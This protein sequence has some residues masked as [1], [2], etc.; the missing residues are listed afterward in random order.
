MSKKNNDLDF[1]D[2]PVV[3]TLCFQGRGHGFYPCQG[4]ESPHASKL[5]QKNILFFLTRVGKTDWFP[6]QKSSWDTA[7]SYWGWGWRKQ[8]PV[9]A[10]LSLGRRKKQP[11]NDMEREHSK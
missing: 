10:S 6:N 5:S 2:G 8:S 9:L 4:T 3:K 7:V 11:W 1:P